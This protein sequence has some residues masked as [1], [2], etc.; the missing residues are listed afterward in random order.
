MHGGYRIPYDASAPLIQ[1]EAGRHV[2]DELWNELHHQGDVGDASNCI[3]AD[4]FLCLRDGWGK[5]SW[6]RLPPELAEYFRSQATPFMTQWRTRKLLKTS[7]ALLN[8]CWIDYGARRVGG[9]PSK[10]NT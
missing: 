4:H 5:V 3:A 9:M 10:D 7:A 1:L 2:W 6:E 8:N